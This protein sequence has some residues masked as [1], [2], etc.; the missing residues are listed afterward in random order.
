MSTR[1]RTIALGAAALAASLAALAQAGAPPAQAGAYDS[2]FEAYRPFS[3]GEVGDWRQANET[4]REIGGW[5]AY[6]REIQQPRTPGPGGAGPQ[7]PAA[8]PRPAASAPAA[9]SQHGNRP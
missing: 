4:V 1:T 2:A 3:T 9:P 6:A 5:R 7:A 8:A